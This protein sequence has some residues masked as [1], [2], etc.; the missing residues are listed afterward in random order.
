M[1]T[2]TITRDDST[3]QHVFNWAHEARAWLILSGFLVEDNRHEFTH[4]YTGW[5][6]KLEVKS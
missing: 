5:K 3:V 6:A 1:T 2:V 4:P